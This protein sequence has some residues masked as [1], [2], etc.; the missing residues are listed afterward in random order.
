MQ[1]A[2]PGCN[3]SAGVSDK[4]MP[5]VV[6]LPHG[7]GHDR[8]GVRLAVAR[9]HAGVSFNDL[10]DEQQIDELCGNAAFVACP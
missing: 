6:S 5:G 1:A 8:P 10:M 4:M 7:F 3:N 2:L 9:S